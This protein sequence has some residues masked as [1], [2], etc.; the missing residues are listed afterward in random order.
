[1]SILLNNITKIHFVDQTSE[2]N[3]H[4]VFNASMINVL[5]GLAPNALLFHYG[6]PS[7]QIATSSLLDE[8]SIENIV[9]KPIN[10]SKFDSRFKLIKLFK[11]FE[12][13]IIRIRMFYK[14]LRQTNEN[15]LIV[16]SITTFTSLL[17]FK[18]LKTFYK[19]QVWCVL[20]GDIDFLY[21]TSNWFEKFNGLVHLLFFKIKANNFNYILLNKIAKNRVVRDGYI[22]ESEV[23][24][25]NHPFKM[26][27]DFDL[28]VK[29]LTEKTTITIGHIGSMELKRKNSHFFYFLA[30]KL[31]SKISDDLITFETIGLITPSILPYKNEWVT[32]IIGNSKPDKPDYLTRNEY[33]NNISKIDFAVFFFESNQYFFRASGAVID[34][35][36]FGIPIIALKHP[37]FENLFEQSG[38]IGYICNDVEEMEAVLNKIINKDINVINDYKMFTENI[39]LLSAKFEVDSIVQDISKQLVFKKGFINYNNLNAYPITF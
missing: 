15:D 12:K 4:M 36:A 34:T 20:H 39:K 23:I 32:E 31:K 38:P 21:F 9:F 37:F 2:R 8:K 25:I 28:G 18:I 13:E 35:I 6:I 7:N 30:E 14:L 10:Y 24:D 1:M 11:Y 33:E 27:N 17:G 16:L 19:S 3:H 5:F 26:L 22:K 29:V